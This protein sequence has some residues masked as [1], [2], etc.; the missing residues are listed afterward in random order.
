M[1]DHRENFEP[2]EVYTLLPWYAA[3]TLSAAD[4]TLVEKTLATEPALR[5]SLAR[6]EE[7]RDE[8]VALNEAIPM[9]RSSAIDALMRRIETDAP[10]RGRS[11]TKGAMARLLEAVGGLS[12]R[13]IAIGMGVAALVIIAQG[14]FITNYLAHQGGDM[15][16]YST[17]SVA[18]AT[19]EQ[20]LLLVQF[21]GTAQLEAIAALLRAEK[22]TII[23]GPKAGGLFRIAVA[24]ADRD[25]VL[26]D[27]KARPD[28]V[29]FA[30]PSK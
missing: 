26:A 17:A 23:D 24:A 15:D 1:T 25:T 6:I 7:E 11:A 28:L 20:A 12:P 22:A 21:V 14:G 29:G 5:A 10:R 16:R 3:G 19:G 9:P 2:D 13:T 27:L 30:G 4:K 18:P 8:T